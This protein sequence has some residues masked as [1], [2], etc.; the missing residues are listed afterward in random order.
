MLTSVFK[1]CLIFCSKNF[2]AK[3]TFRNRVGNSIILFFKRPLVTNE[4]GTVTVNY[5]RQN[6]AGMFLQLPLPGLIFR[7]GIAY[8][9][10]WSEILSIHGTA[11]NQ[12]QKSS[13]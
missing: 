2:S 6:Q 12:L 3:K 11:Q 10:V 7:D 8:N 5:R 1:I 4:F 9:G 13:Y